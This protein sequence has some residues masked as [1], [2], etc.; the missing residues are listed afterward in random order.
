MSVA[1][2][3]L[4]SSLLEDEHFLSR[5]LSHLIDF[6]LHECRRVCRKWKDVCRRLPVKLKN[7]PIDKMADIPLAFPNVVRLSSLEGHVPKAEMSVLHSFSRLTNLNH[8]E[9]NL[10]A[11]SFTIDQH[12][13]TW[14]ATLGQ[15]TSFRVY[16]L[17]NAAP[18]FFEALENMR[19]LTKL[20][21]A[22]DQGDAF[23]I[24]AIVPLKGLQELSIYMSQMTATQ[25]EALFLSMPHLT[26]LKVTQ[27]ILNMTTPPLVVSA[28]VTDLLPCRQ[29]GIL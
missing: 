7:I 27:D 18:H 17:V 6:G 23:Q 15:L 5:V 26:K 29:G 16:G 2:S 9:I 25:G 13:P 8:L 14:F 28:L 22:R 4:I 24:D 12:F 1:E 3:D 21:F 10:S 19:Q 11:L 20:E